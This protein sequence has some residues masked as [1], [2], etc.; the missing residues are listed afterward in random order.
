MCVHK[1]AH[2][3]LASLSNHLVLTI[4]FA[5]DNLIMTLE[6]DP[7]T[8]SSASKQS[9]NTAQR[10]TFTAQTHPITE[11]NQCKL[12]CT[13]STLSSWVIEIAGKMQ[14]LLA[15]IGHNTWAHIHVRLTKTFKYKIPGMFLPTRNR[16]L[17]SHADTSEG[18]KN[19]PPQTLSTDTSKLFIHN[20]SVTNCAR[21][22]H[23]EQYTHNVYVR[24]GRKWV[25]VQAD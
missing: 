17:Q 12:A 14:K 10:Q 13:K 8:H 19:Q 6:S 2:S 4:I 23:H 1:Y 9:H 15:V 5:T 3:S 18:L 16:M 20:S 11:H 24:S 21:V 25:Q 7:P 22:A